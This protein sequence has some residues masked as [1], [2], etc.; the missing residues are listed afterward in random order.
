MAW[1]KPNQQKLGGMRGFIVNKQRPQ[2]GYLLLELVLAMGLAAG[3]LTGI[4]AIATGSL[5]IGRTI[6]E[7]G[8]L[9]GKREA[10]I[11]FLGRSFEQLPGNAVVEL[12]TRETSQ[13]F[14]PRMVIQNAPTSF[15]FEGLP[16]S[17]QAVVL[18]TVQVPSGGVNVVLEYYSEPLLDDNDQLAES[19]PEPAGSIILYRNIHRFEL[20]VL[21]SRTLELISDWDIRGRLPLQVELN[22]VFTPDGK[23][24]VQ[25]F[26]IPPKTSPAT[27]VNGLGQGSAQ[28][29]NQTN[30]GT[31]QPGGQQPSTGQPTPTPGITP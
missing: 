11:E 9:Q 27:L 5:S 29:N 10:L 12:Q 24:V 30:Q 17:A 19:S 14:L 7:E 26:W 22:A 6:L 21:D 2:K 8:R 13:R 3:L 15:A 20:R 23:E 1:N 25:H 16:I 4:F 31:Q 18:T 28:G